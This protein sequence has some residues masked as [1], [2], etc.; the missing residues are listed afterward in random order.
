MTENAAG[1]RYRYVPEGDLGRND[2]NRYYLS[3]R[4]GLERAAEKGAIV[5]AL[6]TLCDCSDMNLTVRLPDGIRGIIPRSEV[7]LNTDGSDTKDI[8]VITRVGKP[9]QF[10]IR[11]FRDNGMTAVLSRRDAQLACW[12]NYISAITPGDIIPARVTH[13]EP[14]GAFCDIGCGIVS[15]ITVDRISVSRISHP[16][17]RFEVGDRIMAIAASRDAGG[18][19]CVTHRE[20]LGTWAENAA[21]FSP[22][23]TACGIIRSVEEYGVFVELAPNLAGLAEL[24]EN[25][26]PGDG[27]SVYIKNIIPERMKVKLVLIDTHA[28]SARMPVKYYVDFSKVTRMDRWQYSPDGC[29]KNVESVFADGVLAQM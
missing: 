27:C 4:E 7:C 26:K 11:T 13:L 3:S 8:A 22:G 2:E 15:L 10:R 24:N 21:H 1:G 20:L 19:I 29:R 28:E 16:S 6:C 9:V 17:D 5:E 23:Q 12:E 18:R 14:F 25:A